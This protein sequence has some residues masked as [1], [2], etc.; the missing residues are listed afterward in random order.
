MEIVVIPRIENKGLWEQTLAKLPYRPVSYT[1]SS[2]DYQLAYQRGHGDSWEECSLIIFWDNQPASLWPLSISTK[3]GRS[4][5][6]SQG[7]PVLP[8]IFVSECAYGSRKRMIKACLDA[9]GRIASDIKIDSWESGEPFSNSMGIS[10]WHA[11][12]LSRG[13]SCQLHYDL[14]LDLCPDLTEIRKNFRKSYKPL[15]SSGLTLW[16]VGILDEGDKTIWQEFRDLHLRVSGR[17]TRSEESWNLQFQ[18]IENQSAFLIWLRNTSG[19]LVGGGFFNF[20]LDE[21][22]YAVGVY[23]RSLFDKPLG[24]VVQFRAITEMK[25]RGVH[26]Y[27]IGARYFRQ[28]SPSPTEKEIKISEFKQGF[29]SHVFPYYRITHPAFSQS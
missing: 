24:H 8:P 16:S 9:A 22:V 27:K 18:E 26:W 17:V 3:D 28:E 1:N 6:T 21:G 25:D 29:A 2:L 20:T 10:E 11:E 12:S 19:A 7:L 23:D 4:S 13:A 5:L 14:Y 15:I